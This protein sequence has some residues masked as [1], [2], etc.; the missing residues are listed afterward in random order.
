MPKLAMA[1]SLVAVLLSTPA[2]ARAY[3]A[4]TMVS[5]PCHED[6]T[7]EALRRARDQLGLEASIDETRAERALIDDVPF[8]VPRDAAD[9][10][11]I[12]LVLGNRHN[13]FKDQE[14]DDLNQLAQLHGDPKRQEEHCLRSPS[15]DGI[16]GSKAALT[17]CRKYILDHADEALRHLDAT[18]GVALD[19]RAKLRVALDLRGPVDAVLPSF[20]VELGHALHALQDGFSHTYRT[21]DQLR[22]VSVLDYVEGIEGTHTERSDGPSHLGLLDAC[23]DL[24]RDRSERLELAISASSELL[25]AALDDQASVAERRAGI[26]AVLDRY[27]SHEDGCD[28]SNDFCDA[29][30]RKYEEAASCA[31]SGPGRVTAAGAFALVALA[32]LTC[33][34]FGRRRP[35][36]ILLTIACVA[37]G[38]V[39]TARAD[40]APPTRPDAGPMKDPPSSTSSPWGVALSLSGSFENPAAAAALGVRYRVADHFSLGVDGEYNP[41]LAPSTGDVRP[42]VVSAYATFIFRMPLSYERI[43]LRSVLQLGA[44]RMMFDLYGVPEGSIGPYVGFNLLGIEF[45]VSRNFSL[46]LDPAHVAIPIPQVSGVPYANPQYRIT[47]GLQWG[48]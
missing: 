5:E 26:D 46:T 39:T 2:S 43:A 18:G 32:G 4:K 17:A 16:E 6:M 41:W 3:S 14:P 11:A 10:E 31:L 34:R 36:P 29:P 30:E 15:Q 24:D 22:V 23:R 20:Y 9:L 33:A 38:S 47:L 40:D 37:F 1:L 25:V 13:D 48:G 42:G 7:F 45:E 8:P 44:S 35:A 12:S 28:A 21:R 19:Q 27:L